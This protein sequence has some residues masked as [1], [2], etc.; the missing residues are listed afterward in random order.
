MWGGSKANSS[1]SRSRRLRTAFG[2]ALPICVGACAVGSGVVPL[3]PDSFTITE[4]RAPVLGGAFEAK[5]VALTEAAQFCAGKGQQFF[6]VSEKEGAFPRNNPWG[7]TDYTV[8]FQC[9]AS[10]DPRLRGGSVATDGA[11]PAPRGAPTSNEGALVSGTGFVVNNQGIVLTNKHVVPNCKAIAVRRPGATPVPADLLAADAQ[12]DLAL[13]KAPATGGSVAQ[14]RDGPPIRQGDAVVAIGFP[15]AGVLS[16]G[17]SLTTGTVS[18]LAGVGND[19]R[20]LQISAPVQPGNS[21]GPLIDQSGR[22][23]G[24]VDAKLDALRTLASS[25]SLPENVNFAIKASVAQA[26]MEA[27]SVAY[28]R[29]APTK[30]LSNAEIGERAQAFTVQVGCAE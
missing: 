22:I 28:E 30:Q 1:G 13:L 3:G 2:A 18:S 9:L 25:G 29:A 21:G 26:F 19:S 14:F 10:D 24:I 15:L 20:F 6:A 5:K 27:N 12:N 4:R 8:N 16:S 17:T 7:N 11:A 23:V